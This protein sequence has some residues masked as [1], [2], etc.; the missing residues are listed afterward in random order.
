VSPYTNTFSDITVI[1]DGR[2]I[3]AHKAVLSARSVQW[4]DIIADYEVNQAAAASYWDD[5]QPTTPRTNKNQ[6]LT[7]VEQR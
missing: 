6:S 7:L 3:R 5:S 2:E 4:H 1:I